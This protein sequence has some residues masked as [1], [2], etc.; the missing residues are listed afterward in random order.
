ME[1]DNLSSPFPS[2][3]DDGN[4]STLCKEDGEGDKKVTKKS[5][6]IDIIKRPFSR[7]SFF[8]RNTPFKNK[9]GDRNGDK[10]DDR[11]RN[12][13]R[14]SKSLPIPISISKSKPFTSSFKTGYPKSSEYLES[15]TL[16]SDDEDDEDKESELLSK[17]VP[18]LSTFIFVDHFSPPK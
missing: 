13:E 9:D 17:S 5:S 4:D 3:I 7:L 1:K 14:L 6:P 12:D 15:N 2:I 8:K 16:S 11:D 10:N 18:D